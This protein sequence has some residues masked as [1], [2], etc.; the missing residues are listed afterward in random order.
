MNNKEAFAA[1]N[2]ADLEFEGTF[3]KERIVVFL[4]TPLD[5]SELKNTDIIDID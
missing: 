2:C 4:Y 5:K 1:P 3:K